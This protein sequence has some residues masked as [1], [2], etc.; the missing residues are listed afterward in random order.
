MGETVTGEPK[1]NT[2]N[3]TIPTNED[4]RSDFPIQVNSDNVVTQK[5]TLYF[6][7]VEISKLSKRQMKKYKKCMKWQEVKKEKRLKEKIKMKEKKKFQKLNDIDSGPSRKEL[8]RRPK[9]KDSPCK[10]GVCIDLGFDH[11]M[12]DKVRIIAI[13]KYVRYCYNKLNTIC[14]S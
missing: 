14:Q 6:N 10:I 9:M 12:I 5:G 8:K 13:L 4:E 2:D 7:G 11:L 3:R 1:Q